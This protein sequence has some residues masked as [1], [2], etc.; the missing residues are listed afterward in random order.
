LPEHAAEILDDEIRA[1]ICPDK[2]N[3]EEWLEAHRTA[4]S[5]GLRSNVTI[6]FGTV[7]RRGTSRAL[8]RSRAL[9]KENRRLTEFV[10]FHSCTGDRRRSS[11]RAGRGAVRPSAKF[12]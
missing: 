11:C 4:H 2:V 10:R 8:V 7:E 12:C 6:M 1:I 9:Q 3:T 5:V